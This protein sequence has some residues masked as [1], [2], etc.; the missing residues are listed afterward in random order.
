MNE[1]ITTN[2]KLELQQKLGNNTFLIYIFL[3]TLFLIII[4]LCYFKIYD[5]KEFEAIILQDE[6]GLYF[7]IITNKVDVDNL[8]ES[9][10]IY[11]NNQKIEIIT[12]TIQDFYYPSKIIKFYIQNKTLEENE[13]IKIQFY[14]NHERIIKKI[15]KYIMGG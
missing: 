4:G 6:E 3:Y 10:S 5:S 13:E 14:Y 7:E 11:I 15:K 1:Y 2:V 12:H 9:G 8:V